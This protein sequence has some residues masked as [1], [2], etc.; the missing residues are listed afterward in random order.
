MNDRNYKI[1]I[2]GQR[3][4]KKA[5]LAQLLQVDAADIE[6]INTP[7]YLTPDDVAAILRTSRMQVYHLI[8]SGRLVATNIGLGGQR[9]KWR[10]SP[11]DLA[12]FLKACRT[13]A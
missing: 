1:F 13:S 5:D 11:A 12:E 2:P 6:I 10:I 3:G 7:A 9:A 4:L 8:N